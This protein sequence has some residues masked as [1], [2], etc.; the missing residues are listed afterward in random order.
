M[1]LRIVTDP[2]FICKIITLFFLF[3]LKSKLPRIVTT[4]LLL[5]AY[6]HFSC[7]F[8]IKAA[9]NR[10]TWNA[11]ILISSFCLLS[12]NFTPSRFW[13]HVRAFF[14]HVQIF[15]VIKASKAVTMMKTLKYCNYSEHH[16]SC[17][18]K[19]E[20]LFKIL[21]DQNSFAK[22]F[23]YFACFLNINAA[24]NRENKIAF[25]L[26]SSFSFFFEN[27]IPSRI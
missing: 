7:F 14:T 20:I 4:K 16:F 15:L 27:L 18:W 23:P 9:T 1:L 8:R 21:I 17:F 12:E 5:F 19:N 24:T 13:P 25:I 11:V 10:K 6:P 22:S 26:M 2:K 3:F